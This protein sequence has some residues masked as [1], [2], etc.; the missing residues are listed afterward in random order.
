MKFKALQ[1]A[2]TIS[3]AL[4]LVEPLVDTKKVQKLASQLRA[5]VDTAVIALAVPT[6]GQEERVGAYEDYLDALHAPVLAIASIFTLAAL[7]DG[8][9]AK[10][11]RY[12]D[13]S[14]AGHRARESVAARLATLLSLEMP[15]HAG[16]PASAAKAELQRAFASLVRNTE[17]LTLLLALGAD[18]KDAAVL[19]KHQEQL[20]ATWVSGQGQALVEAK[21]ALF[22]VGEPPAAKAQVKAAI[23]S[24]SAA[25][26]WRDFALDW[27][28]Y[29]VVSV[30]LNQSALAMLPQVRTQPVAK[31][32]EGPT[33]AELLRTACLPTIVGADESAQ[34]VA[35]RKLDELMAGLTKRSQAVAAAKRQAA[36]RRKAA[37]K[38]RAVEAVRG[39]GDLAKVLKAH[40]ELL[41]QV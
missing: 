14:T 4:L 19:A 25:P 13:T 38:A 40:P 27:S 9:E 39:L 20:H 36:E 33:V 15:A 28:G 17:W 29:A 24:D 1:N 26:G 41:Q 11:A 16:R 2:L 12:R 3:K 22:Q 32:V 7:V 31:D 18:V 34:V 35:E 37:Q 30:E 21:L 5:R 6:L 10:G 23:S 8:P